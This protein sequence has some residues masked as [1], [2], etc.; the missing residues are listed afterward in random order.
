MRETHIYFKHILQG[1]IAEHHGSGKCHIRDELGL[2]L[3]HP[4]NGK[5]DHRERAHE[6]LIFTF[7]SVEFFISE[8]L[9]N[10]AEQH[11]TERKPKKPMRGKEHNE[12]IRQQADG[13][14]EECTQIQGGYEIEIERKDGKGNREQIKVKRPNGSDRDRI[15]AVTL[16][17]IEGHH[18]AKPSPHRPK[19]AAGY[20]LIPTERFCLCG[21]FFAL[22]LGCQNDIDKETHYQDQ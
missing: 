2:T 17:L 13:I 4:T 16:V 1:V 20:L 21:A 5:T 10:N 14:H 8:E 22:S 6:L 19:W 18:G 15:K 9:T 12:N 7:L 3:A 11:P